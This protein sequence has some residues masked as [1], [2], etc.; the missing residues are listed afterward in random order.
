MLEVIINLVPFGVKSRRRK[1]LKIK[2]ANVGKSG[3]RC[4]LN[5]SRLYSYQVTTVDE[6]N[7]IVDHGILV[8]DFDR[9]QREYVL[10]GKVIDALKG[11]RVV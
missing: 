10:V 9:A 2:I 6:N 3:M 11:K 1:L 7:G 8:R 5:G 4:L